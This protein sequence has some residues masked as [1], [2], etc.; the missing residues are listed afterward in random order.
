MGPPTPNFSAVKEVARE[1]KGPGSLG[2]V[3]VEQIREGKA[4]SGSLQGI[5]R[6]P[7]VLHVGE[8]RSSWGHGPLSIPIGDLGPPW[9]HVGTL[10]VTPIVA[11]H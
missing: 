6:Y 10:A 7:T 8:M 9:S 2:T 11:N 5:D 4:T 1:L 3:L